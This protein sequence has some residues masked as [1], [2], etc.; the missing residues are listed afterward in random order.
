[1]PLHLPYISSGCLWHPD[2][3]FSSKI[4]TRVILPHSVASARL[5]HHRQHLILHTRHRSY[6]HSTASSLHNSRSQF[7]ILPFIIILA[8]GSGS[9]VLLVTSRGSARSS[10]RQ[11]GEQE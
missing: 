10:Q 3:T 6:Q 9:Y 5:P 4:V 7:K 8:I 1:M 2:L 11:L